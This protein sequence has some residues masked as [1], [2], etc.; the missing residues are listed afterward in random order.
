M[1]HKINLFSIADQL[2]DVIILIE[3]AKSEEPITVKVNNQEERQ[4]TTQDLLGF[5][6]NKVTFALC[7]LA[8]LQETLLS[9][10]SNDQEIE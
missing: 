9:I 1:E 4:A 10:A 2:N 6:E 3:Q 5:I 7:D 8:E